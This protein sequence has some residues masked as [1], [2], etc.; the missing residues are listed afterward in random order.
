MSVTEKPLDRSALFR[1]MTF[2]DELLQAVWAE[3]N[4]HPTDGDSAA[5]VLAEVFHRVTGEYADLYLN[6]LWQGL[7][8]AE[9]AELRGARW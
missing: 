6:Q 4:R 1:V 9:A 2:K 7:K 3:F 5:D 8:A